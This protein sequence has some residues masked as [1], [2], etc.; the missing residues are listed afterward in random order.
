[1]RKGI[2]SDLFIYFRQ[3]AKYYE[4]VNPE[5]EKRDNLEE[6]QKAVRAIK[7]A[8]AKKR[9]ELIAK[10]DWLKSEGLFLDYSGDSD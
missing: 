5:V 10:H 6:K 8:I 3:K 4:R 1:M 9:E 2:P 7:E